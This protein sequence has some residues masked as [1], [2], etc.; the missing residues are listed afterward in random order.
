MYVSER[1]M[2]ALY[3]NA[4]QPMQSLY[5]TSCIKYGKSAFQHELMRTIF[6]DDT[7]EKPVLNFDTGLDTCEFH[8]YRISND[9]LSK[10]SSNVVK[11]PSDL[12]MANPAKDTFKMWLGG[13]VTYVETTASL[14]LCDAFGLKWFVDGSAAPQM[15]NE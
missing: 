2:S 13:N 1:C 4:L 6:V 9:A 10:K 12:F 11:E 14:P 7:G 15:S 3:R 8:A 5:K